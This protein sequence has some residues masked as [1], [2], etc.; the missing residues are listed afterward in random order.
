VKLRAFRRVRVGK[1][2]LYECPFCGRLIL[3]RCCCG[4]ERVKAKKGGGG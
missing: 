3:K 1:S 2:Y 4:A